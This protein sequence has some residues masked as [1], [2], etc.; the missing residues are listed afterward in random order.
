MSNISPQAVRDIETVLARLRNGPQ[1]TGIANSV[2]H[3]F[4]RAETEE[5]RLEVIV[6]AIETYEKVLIETQDMATRALQNAQP[7]PVVL[8]YPDWL[9]SPE[10]VASRPETCRLRETCQCGKGA[11]GERASGLLREKQS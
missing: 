7:V 4:I 6:S 2:F 1:A 8:K 11:C 10:L 5:Q 3:R 9:P